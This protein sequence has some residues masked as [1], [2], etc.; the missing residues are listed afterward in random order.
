MDNYITKEGGEI[1]M[2][3]YN[4]PDNT[5][6]FYP[7]L[8][9]QAAVQAAANAA[10]NQFHSLLTKWEEKNPNYIEHQKT[11]K[12]IGLFIYELM[13]VDKVI[14]VI[15][16]DKRRKQLA[17]ALTHYIFPYNQSAVN[18]M[19]I[20]EDIAAFNNIQDPQ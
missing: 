10:D 4:P 6:E 16:D 2:E 14:P 7:S 9:E 12:D 3:A 15:V 1:S 8:E 11:L 20:Q 13:F 5:D 18:F 17:K 19:F